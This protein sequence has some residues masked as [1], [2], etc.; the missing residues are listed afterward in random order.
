MEKHPLPW[1]TKF[2]FEKLFPLFY[3][4]STQRNYIYKKLDTNSC[5]AKLRAISNLFS[6]FYTPCMASDR[7]KD[8][9]KVK[10]VA[11]MTTPMMTYFPNTLW[12]TIHVNVNLSEQEL[13]FTKF[14]EWL[15]CPDGGRRYE[16][17]A[18][19]VRIK[20]N[21]LYSLLTKINWIGTTYWITFTKRNTT[22]KILKEA[23]NVEIIPWLFET[24]FT[25]SCSVTRHVLKTPEHVKQ[26]DV[27]CAQSNSQRTWQLTGYSMWYNTKP[28]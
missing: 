9:E 10:Q 16:D 23:V 6:F 1:F 24:V 19:V 18:A 28:K 11:P 20:F 22:D 2:E 25:F 21:W 14:E 27:R 12:V 7:N 13:N 8:E 4:V 26:F 15:K 3:I 5:F 17:C